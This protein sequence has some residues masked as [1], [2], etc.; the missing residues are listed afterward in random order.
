MAAFLRT[1]TTLILGTKNAVRRQH[2]AN[3]KQLLMGMHVYSSGASDCFL[4][5]APTSYFLA[6]LSWEKLRATF[7]VASKM[8]TNSERLTLMCI[9]RAPPMLGCSSDRSAS[10]LLKS[11]SPTEVRVRIYT[12]PTRSEAYVSVIRSKLKRSVEEL[13]A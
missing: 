9:L 11:Y 2:F 13:A 5:W 3:D 7:D 10:D 6:G 12:R 8:T 1:S 4:T